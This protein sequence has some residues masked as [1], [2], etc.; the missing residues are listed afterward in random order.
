MIKKNQTTTTKTN[1]TTPN[2]I[3]HISLDGTV[4]ICCYWFALS[5][6]WSHLLWHKFDLQLTKGLAI[7]SMGKVHK[8]RTQQTNLNRGLQ[9]AVWPLLIIMDCVQITVKWDTSHCLSDDWALRC[10]ICSQ[11][12]SHGI[13]LWGHRHSQSTQLLMLDLGLTEKP[14]LFPLLIWRGIHKNQG[15]D[16]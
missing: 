12:S 7:I 11:G 6:M 9:S 15:E 3:A 10:Q 8:V 1:P 4:L 16:K 5:N 2:L 14:K 13:Q